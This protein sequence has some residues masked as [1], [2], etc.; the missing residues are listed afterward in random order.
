MKLLLFLYSKPKSE[1]WNELYIDS[2]FI[3][4]WPIDRWQKYLKYHIKNEKMKKGLTKLCNIVYSHTST[5]SMTSTH[6]KYLDQ[7]SKYLGLHTFTWVWVIAYTRKMLTPQ[8]CYEPGII[9]FAR[10]D[11]VPQSETN[12]IKTRSSISLRKRRLNFW[13]KEKMDIVCMICQY[14]FC[15]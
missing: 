4:V 6:T 1:Y 12:L 2:V 8:R 5:Q 15:V 14:V 11:S 13:I 7:C 10:Y 3:S 9:Q